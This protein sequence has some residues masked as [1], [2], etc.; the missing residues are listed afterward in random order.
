[1]FPQ[2]MKVAEVVPIYK[3][4]DSR[5]VSNYRP[6]SV[7]PLFSKIYE[8]LMYNRLL[9]FIE[10][11]NLFYK[12]QFGFRSKHG[13]NLA[14]VILIYKILSALDKGNLVLGVFLDLKK[15]FDAVNNAILLNKLYKYGV[16][17]V[18]FKWLTDYLKDRKQYVCFDGCNSRRETVTCGVPQGSILGP[19]LFLMYIND[20]AYVSDKL[21][22][23]IFAD[24][25]NVFLEGKNLV[26]TCDTMSTELQKVNLWLQANKLT[27]NI[28]KT[29]Y[30]CFKSPRK[31]I[32]SIHS[33][34]INK[35]KIEFVSKSK[36][37]G[38]VL[39][40]SL[41]WIDH[42]KSVKTRV[43]KEMGVICKARKYLNQQTL[44]VLYYSMVYPHLIYCVEVWGYASQIHLSSLFKPQKR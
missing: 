33:V 21:L 6:V 16:R 20:L 25:T 5:L 43:A 30:M 2:E 22:P 29:Q 41:S 28:A 9:S 23:I 3:S 1:M 38:I 24:D 31:K 4:G 15:A 10:K 34:S 32:D 27:L 19:L 13:S 42:I 14:Q 39:D 11:N 40:E 8:K 37:I 36:F 7:L 17:G 26:D 35:T 44:K 12:F 18:T